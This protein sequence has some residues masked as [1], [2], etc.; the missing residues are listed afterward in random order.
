[1]LVLYVLTFC[2]V[3]I[4]LVF[5]FSGISKVRDMAQFRQTLHAFDVLPRNLNNAAA[6]FFLGGEFVVVAL[7]FISGP[8]LIFGF[9]LA[10]VLLLL[11]CLALVSVLARGIHTTCNCFGASTKDISAFDV[12]RNIGLIICALTGVAM[13]IEA[14]STRVPLSLLEWVLI[15]LGAGVFVMIW[16]Q[17]GELVQLF[18]QN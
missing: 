7:V 13:L 12:W 6:M 15:S 1:M 5:V 8:L 10:S 9:F 14:K 16:L 11:F 17:L 3:V 4:G 2:K 18:R